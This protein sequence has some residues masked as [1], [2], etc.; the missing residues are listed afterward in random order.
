LPENG[1]GAF[2]QAGDTFTYTGPDGEV[3]NDFKYFAVK[4]VYLAETHSK[5][6]RVKDMRA[7]AVS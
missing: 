7:I 4:I 1:K 2:L 6:P 5:V 3:Y